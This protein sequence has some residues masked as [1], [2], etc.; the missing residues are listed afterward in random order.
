MAPPFC[1]LKMPGNTI[2]YDGSAFPRESKTH[3]PP[4]SLIPDGIPE[5]TSKG[6]RRQNWAEKSKPQSV[7]AELMMKTRSED[8]SYE[9]MMRWGPRGIVIRSRLGFYQGHGSRPWN[10]IEMSGIG[11]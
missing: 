2:I 8:P 4:V 11:Y 10:P 1:A 3:L 9:L 6:V 5:H 7:R